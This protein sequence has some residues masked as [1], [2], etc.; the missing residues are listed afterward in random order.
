MLSSLLIL[1]FILTQFA[2]PHEFMGV[3]ILLFF[4]INTITTA[5]TNSIVGK[6]IKKLWWVSVAF[7]IM[8][9]LSYWLVLKEIIIDLTFYAVIYLIIGLVFMI[10]SAIVANWKQ[11]S[12]NK[13]KKDWGDN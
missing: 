2:E 3:M 12:A 1:P 7:P 8:F 9:L 13:I 4:I 11:K 6:D 10:G 5:V